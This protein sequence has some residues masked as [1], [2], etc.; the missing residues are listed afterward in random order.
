MDRE[1]SNILPFQGADSYDF[2]TD[3]EN[4]IETQSKIL[5][6]E[7]LRSRHPQ[8]GLSSRRNFSQAGRRKP[9]PLAAG[10]QKRRRNSVS[11]WQSQ[12]E[13]R[14]NSRLMDVNFESTDRS[15]RRIVNAHIAHI[16]NR[17]PERYEATTRA[18]TGSRTS[19]AN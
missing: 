7:R 8:C 13:A 12:R 2:M 4:Y 9:W 14:S 19:S 18:T 11:S 10:E 6:S 16:S 17:I 1:N 5:T 3:L 15:L